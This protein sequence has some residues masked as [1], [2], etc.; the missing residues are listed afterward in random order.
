MTDRPDVET[1]RPLISPRSIAIIG[2]SD[3]PTRIGGRPLGYMLKSGFQ[4]PIWPVNPKRETVQGLQAFASVDAL[5]GAP[6]ACI[7]AVP[8]AAVPDTLEALAA[9][10]AKAA[11]VFSSGFAEMGEEGKAAQD[12]VRAIARAGG[13]R[14]LGP[15]C[16]GVFNAHNGWIATFSSSVE[17]ELPK[18]GP[19]AIASQ[20]GAY[21]SHAF[22][23]MRTRGVQTGILITTGNEADVDLADAI[24]YLVR[25]EHT[26]VIAAYAEG[27]RDGDA[28]RAALAAAAAAGK[29]VIFMKVGRSAIGAAAAASHTA[30]LAGSDRVYD[31]LFA[32]Y[33]VLRVSSTDQLLD[34]CYAAAH[35][36]FPAGNRLGLMTISGGVGVQMAD[37]AEDLGMDVAEMP[38]DA[39]RTLQD[40]LPYAAVRNPVD[41]TAQ[42]FNDLSLVGTNLRMMLDQGRYDVVVAFFTV[43]AGSRTIAGP[44]IKILA[45]I[46]ER[47]RE[48]SIILSLV[49]TGDIVR[50]YEDGG[51]PVYEDP[52]RA[53]AAA[54]ALTGFG[55]FF[56]RPAEP[57]PPVAPAGA[58]SVG[59]D[60]L[61]EHHATDL[62]EA[63]GVPFVARR[64]V[65][66]PD[67]AAAAAAELGGKVVLK[68]ASPDIQHKTEV[69]GVIVGVQGDEAVRAAY[70]SLTE[71][72][73]L[74]RPDAAIDGVIVAAMAP[75]GVEAVVGVQNDP[76]FGPVV[77]VGLGGV[78]VEVLED[79][80]FRLAPFGVAEARRMIAEL[81]GARI[82]AGVRGAPPADV[83]A[84][85]DLLARVSVFAAAEAERLVS[86]DLNPVRVLEAG[87]GV[88]ALDALV[89]PAGMVPVAIEEVA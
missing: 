14:V 79:V 13:V 75:A 9:K 76:T 17:Q 21:G 34:A 70:A 48:R 35:G 15:N 47:F 1:L 23:L 49:A 29:P 84:L 36:R 81:K 28:L 12:R 2:A 38:K 11:V 62:L 56:A 53:V 59:T 46:R 71:R 83:E 64:L 67:Q 42:A 33:G 72:V 89:V 24:G 87:N 78:L 69:G 10:G 8:A 65:T 30:A 6:D 60:A 16:L 74:L 80:S 20:S 5:P 88:V 39:Q 68:I 45:E 61:A 58:P 41:V 52:T 55:R 54:A 43:V 86:V 4:G 18:P 27:I 25:D 31:G 57:A 22:A 51:F 32:Q 77:M 7:V 40:L 82:F 3:D 50:Q 26:K 37:S 66:S 73:P 19:V 44:L 63:W 85:A